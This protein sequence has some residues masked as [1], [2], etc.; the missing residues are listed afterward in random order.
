MPILPALSAIFSKG[1]STLVD[2]VGK[3]LDNL[4]T[5]KEELA[6]VK[7]AV[8]KEVNRHL[9]SVQDKTLHETELYLKDVDSARNMQIE[10]LKQT[11]M[12]SKRFVYY[13]AA[14]VVFLVFCFDVTL[15]FVHYPAENRDMINMIAGCLNTS[16]L[17]TVI[18][19]FFGSSKSSSDKQIQMD[20]MTDKVIENK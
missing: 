9:E 8:E 15:F 1:A 5:N 6:S 19:F 17:A 12:F 20:K 16:A 10:A 7:L 18:S 2:S 4:I 13:L 11:D 3:T 14:G